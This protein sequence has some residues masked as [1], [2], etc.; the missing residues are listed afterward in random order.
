M[1]EKHIVIGL[2]LLLFLTVLI[3][4]VS[5]EWYNPFSWGVDSSN[6]INKVGKWSLDYSTDKNT[7]VHVMDKNKQK[8]TICLIYTNVTSKKDL[9]DINLYYGDDKEGKKKNKDKLKATTIKEKDSPF[10]QDMYGYCYTVKDKEKYV[11]FN[12][13]STVLQYLE[14]SLELR[15]EYNNLIAETSLITKDYVYKNNKPHKDVGIGSDVLLHEFKINGYAS[16][17]DLVNNI[18]AVD[19]RTGEVVERDL[20]LFKKIQV[21]ETFMDFEVSE[22]LVNGTNLYTQTK[23]VTRLKDDW[24]L[25]SPLDL[26]FSESLDIAI[27]GEVQQGDY[28]D[29][30][31]N[32]GGVDVGYYFA[33]ISGDFSS[34]LE[35]YYS[36]D[37]NSGST[38]YDQL[39]NENLTNTGSVTVGN[40]GLQNKSYTWD[41]G[42]LQ[43]LAG[44]VTPFETSG[45]MTLSLWFR[46]NDTNGN[47]ILYSEG[48]S[49]G[50]NVFQITIDSR[51]T[52]GDGSIEFF[53]RDNSASTFISQ[54]F[55]SGYDDGDWHHIVFVNSGSTSYKI[56][57]DG[58]SVLN[59]SYSPGS[60]SNYNNIKFGASAKSPTDDARFDGQMDEIGFWSSVLTHDDVETIYNGGSGIPYGGAGP[61]PV[62]NPPTVTLSSPANNTVYNS[63]SQLVNFQCY[64]EDD[65]SITNGSLYIDGSLDQTDT[66]I[67]NAST[68][69]F[70]KTLTPE[71][72]TWYCDGYDNSSQ[73]TVTQARWLEVRAVPNTLEV[74]S[75]LPID[76]YNSTSSSVN[77]TCNASDNYGVVN[78]SLSVG[79]SIVETVTGSGNTNLSLSSIETVSDGNNINW[80]CIAYDNMTMVTSDTKKLS[81]DTFN[82]LLDIIIPYSAYGE[83]E[84]GQ[85]LN[86]NFTVS[87][88]NLANCTYAY[89]ITPELEES[90]GSYL[91]NFSGW[92]YVAD[93]DTAQLNLNFV[94]PVGSTSQI[95]VYDSAYST[96][97][98]QHSFQSNYANT[99]ESLSFLDDNGWHYITGSYN[100]LGTCPRYEKVIVYDTGKI[101]NVYK[102][103]VPIDCELNTTF[104]YTSGN[105]KIVVTA[106][107]TFGN[108]V[109]DKKSWAVV[110]SENSRTFNTRVIELTDEDFKLNITLDNGYSVTS[111]KLYY[112]GTGHTSSLGI[113]DDYVVLSN[114][115]TISDVNA[116]ENVSFFWSI[117]LNDTSVINTTLSNQT[118][119]SILVDNCSTYTFPLYNLTMRNEENKSILNATEYK[120]YIEVEIVLR[121]RVY[122]ELVANYSDSFSEINPV[123]ICINEDIDGNS[124]RA[125]SIFKYKAEKMT[126]EY[127]HVQNFT[128]DSTSMYQNISLYPVNVSKGQEFKITYRDSS[129]NKVPEAIVHIVRQYNSDGTTRIVEAPKIGA[130]GST[131][132][133]LVIND[134]VYNIIFLLDGTVLATFNNVIAKCQNPSFETCEIDVNSFGSSIE[135]EDFENI[136]DFSSTL[137]YNRDTRRVSST[138][139]IPSGIA[140]TI[141]MQVSLY[142]GLG[143]TSVCS[144]TLLATSGTL[145]CDVPPSF[146]NSTIIAKLYKGVSEKRSG[147]LTMSQDPRDIYTGSLMFIAILVFLTFISMGVSS[148]P[149]YS[150]IFAVIGFIMLIMMNIVYTPGWIGVGATV[151]WLILAVIMIIV[152]GGNRG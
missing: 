79:G 40:S 31:F 120:T 23:E 103:Y 22:T 8:T 32:I 36:L 110:Y 3:P 37:E 46:S 67:S 124:L 69:T 93:K 34:N 13:H 28:Y 115:L 77:F 21:E 138:F 75:L 108:T 42:S 114:T 12:D 129:Y 118:I 111:A 104:N 80:Y 17:D 72:Y 145:F 142:D 38:A 50:T 58:T 125:D 101:T 87:D 116:V 59:A 1:K 35:Y 133:H 109:I 89:N 113:S 20:K 43:Y 102:D 9:P 92:F 152:K 63:N 11:K 54:Q 126:E 134:V 150:G 14:D 90:D 47:K 135:P 81:V 88:N 112:N 39:G 96:S 151:L 19:M 122:N 99:N 139:V 74:T 52:S 53:G 57:I 68:V 30:V 62:D 137:T 119:I 64:Y 15:D 147:I 70:P 106:N 6:A 91:G 24:V 60:V 26:E 141:S 48:Y 41:D 86:L 29:V 27:F 71:N 4:V 18:H 44:S 148:Q 7:Y 97:G 85:E 131:I 10:F 84:S 65:Q 56:Y 73:R 2:M 45:S 105:N 51:S 149:L 117:I 66:T 82:P 76:A 136:G 146:G 144:N 33:T 100:C 121:D 5:A 130:D 78:I 140:D 83:L 132:A 98:S 127:F 143:N 16:Y 25:L 128:F 49:S 123:T 61:S 107:D 55:G 94:Y 95:R